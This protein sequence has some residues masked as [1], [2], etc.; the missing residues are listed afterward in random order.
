MSFSNEEYLEMAI[1]YGQCDR[2]AA[3]AARENAIHLPDRRQPDNHVIYFFEIHYTSHYSRAAI[4]S[5]SLYERSAPSRSR[6][7]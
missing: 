2:N 1:L 4:A 5:S 6:L 3:A 7:S